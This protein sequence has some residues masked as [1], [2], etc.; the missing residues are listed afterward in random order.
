M[1]PSDRW[2][3]P[4]ARYDGRRLY[5]VE[6]ALVRADDGSVATETRSFTAAT[7]LGANKA[8]ALAC[9]E[10]GRLARHAI[11]SGTEP[12]AVW[13]VRVTDHGEVD[14]IDSHTL[15]DRWED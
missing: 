2:S 12:W 13:D 1:A 4:P 7:S 14:A 15:L 6:L 9:Q 3:L 8:I 5:G 10:V 11:E